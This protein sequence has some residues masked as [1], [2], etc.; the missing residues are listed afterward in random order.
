M[1]QSAYIAKRAAVKSSPYA[2]SGTEK[3]IQAY[4][5]KQAEKRPRDFSLE[6]YSRQIFEMFDGETVRVKL[7]CKN[8]LMRYVIDRFGE[9]VETE[10]ATEET[11]YAYPDVALSPNFYSWLFKFAGKIVLLSP[12]KAKEEYIAKARSILDC[13]IQAK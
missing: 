11:F 13:S 5:V 8:Y 12:E 2:K 10:I 9:H 1:G 4:R 3:A 7:E 6:R